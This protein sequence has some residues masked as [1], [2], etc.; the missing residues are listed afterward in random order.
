MLKINKT[1][2]EIGLEK[3]IKILHMTDSHI[4]FYFESRLPDGKMQYVTSRGDRGN[5]GE[6]TII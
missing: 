3:P 1:T 2:I 5:A 6:I 4:H